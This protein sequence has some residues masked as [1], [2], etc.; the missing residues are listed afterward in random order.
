MYSI[1]YLDRISKKVEIESVYGA[2]AL[3]FL[4]GESLCSKVL[5]KPL[6]LALA[7]NPAFSML[8]GLWQKLPWTKHRIAPFI[9]TFGIDKTEFL[10]S[11]DSFSSFNDFFTRKLKA[12]A[13]PIAKGDDVAII[14]ADG[15]YLFF[16]KIDEAE[17]FLVKG[18][19]FS[20]STLL[21]DAELAK[22][23]EQGSMVIARLCPT[24]YHRF[25]F[26]MD[27]TPEK[28]R[29]ING[30]FYSVNPIALK[31][32]IE[33]FTQNKRI[34]TPLTHTQFGKVLYIEV[35]ATNVGSI[36]QTYKPG[37]RYCKGDEKGYFSFGAS[38]L[39]LLFEKDQIQFDED[40]LSATQQNIEIKCLLGQPL[41]KKIKKT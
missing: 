37:N 40:L 7:R 38:S 16:Q 9:E 4:Y 27:C 1:K 41:G 10:D 15:R 25:H 13:R 23:Y 6:L 17:G 22:K 35:G 8:Y 2:Q 24:D 31:K 28:T 11:V 18:K 5:G 32:N 14:P 36:I 12:E 20:L 34:V 21:D 19:K 3:Q 33:I 29:L 39:I 30:W 26:P